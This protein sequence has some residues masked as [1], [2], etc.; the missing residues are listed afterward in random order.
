MSM[1]S[2][3]LKRVF[4]FLKENST[5]NQSLQYAEYRKS[6]SFCGS[7]EERLRALLYSSLVS[8]SKPRLESVAEFWKIFEAYKSIDGRPTVISLV[9][10]FGG[11]KGCNLNSPF[12]SLFN[13]VKSQ[14]GWGKKTAALFVKNVIKIH[15]SS[16]S[17]LHFFKDAKRHIANIDADEVYLPVDKV[18]SHI[19]ESYFDLAGSSFESINNY[20]KSYGYRASEMIIWDDL[21][22][23]G[24]IT[25]N[26]K[27]GERDTQW[28]GDKFWS[29][30]FTQK[31]KAKEIEKLAKKFCHILER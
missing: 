18:I 12:K 4:E 29:L 13:T 25:Q 2:K 1:S 22:F 24:F 16:D 21:W 30:Q 20:I 23:W 8:Q 31:D 27:D 5:W 15:Q 11:E 3:K 10:F 28:N 7:D 6:L 9:D 19:F 26:S 14:P 17:K